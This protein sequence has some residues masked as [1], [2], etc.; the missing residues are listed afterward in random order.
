MSAFD[1]NYKRLKII[2]VLFVFL[3]GIYFLEWSCFVWY[4]ST[5]IDEDAPVYAIDPETGEV[6]E[7]TDEYFENESM[8]QM[9]GGTDFNF[10]GFMTFTLEEIPSWQRLIFTPMTIV[11]WLVALYLVIDMLYIWIKALPFT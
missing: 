2:V 3:T 5:Q 10:F 11:I 9:L 6:V 8:V 7:I 4:P 1:P